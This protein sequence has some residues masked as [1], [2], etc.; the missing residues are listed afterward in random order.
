MKCSLSIFVYPDDSVIIETTDD[1][2]TELTVVIS[3]VIIETDSL[4][5]CFEGSHATL[6]AET[7]FQTS[8]A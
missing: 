6:P 8:L 4:D 3:D 5:S 7:V 2:S 1:R